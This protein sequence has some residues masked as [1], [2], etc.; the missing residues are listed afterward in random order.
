MSTE[1]RLQA[2]IH[3][4][5]EGGWAPWI[6]RALLAM[7]VVYVAC[8]WFFKD[9]GFRGLGH[10]KA[11]D[12]AQISRELARGHGFST[13]LIRPATLW[14]LK[15]QE[16][17]IPKGPIP[18]TFHAPLNPFLGSLVLRAFPQAATMT[19]DGAVCVGDKLLAGLQLAFFL[20]AVLVHHRVTL[21]LFDR[22]LASLTTGL[23]LLCEAFWD[24]SM[25]GLPQ[26]LMLFLF[27]CALYFMVR[28]LQASN[29]GT[30]TVRWSACSGACLGL[31]ALTHPLTLFLTA[32]SVL[33]ALAFLRLKGRDCAVLALCCLGIFSPWLLRNSQVCGSPLGIGFYSTLTEVCGS[34]GMIQRNMHLDAALQGVSPRLF[35]LK[36]RR[37][38]QDQL[39]GLYQHLGFLLPAP[40]FFVALLHP[41]RRAETAGLRWWLL[42]LWILALFGMAAVGLEPLHPAIQP[43]LLKANDL[44]ILFAPIFATYGLAFLLVLWSRLEIPGALA[45]RGFL[46][47]V[48]LISALPFLSQLVELHRAQPKRIHWPPY[49][50]PYISMLKEWTEPDEA[51][52]SDMPWALAWYA[53]RRSLWLPLKRSDYLSLHAFQT[54]GPIVGLYLSP[55]T[56]NRSFWGDI[57]RGEFSDWTPFVMHQTDVPDFP[58][59]H[60]TAMPVDDECV[61]YTDSPR[62]IQRLP[63]RTNAPGGNP[64]PQK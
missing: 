45:H 58:L 21:R 7:A 10:E 61:F 39:A 24:F 27:S 37:Q 38:I 35:T 12:Q 30:P 63:G 53:D 32:G 36:I 5:E 42:T 23:L 59:Q 28:L 64:T 20:L 54:L 14:Q 52:L 15:S 22:R 46:A 56:G 34:E 31:L 16:L 17:P 49:V 26:M 1:N 8:A 11:M 19:P 41:F 44:H 51:I 13:L 55:V 4:L 18:D 2:L 3:R 6:G 29:S 47:G 43:V 25:S 60:C 40:L 50:P 48:F 33:A 62:W 9:S 57:A